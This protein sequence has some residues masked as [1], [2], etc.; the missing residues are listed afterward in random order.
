MLKQLNKDELPYAFAEWELPKGVWITSKGNKI[1]TL[2]NEE[3]YY[4]I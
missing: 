4:D 2:P 3:I 1:K